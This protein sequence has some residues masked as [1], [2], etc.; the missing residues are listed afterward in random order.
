VA[1]T[2]ELKS[3]DGGI[4]TLETVVGEM[5]QN[6]A[7]LQSEIASLQV[8]VTMDNTSQSFFFAVTC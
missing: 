2:E 6:I 8:S 4:E 7:T 1:K 5:S 3:K